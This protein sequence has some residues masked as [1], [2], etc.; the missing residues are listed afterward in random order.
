VVV[1]ER[2]APLDARAVVRRRARTFYLASLFLPP[3]SRQDVHDIY[4]Y[5]RHVDDLVD[6]PPVGWTHASVRRALDEL[7]I[8]LNGTGPTNRS[9]GAARRIAERYDIPIQYLGMVLE[10]ARI[11]L[12]LQVLETREDLRRYAVLMAGSVGIVMAHVLGARTA[13]ALAA[14]RSLG[15]AM[16]LTNILRDVGEDASRGRIYLPRT[17]LAAAGCSVDSIRA[18]V[19]TPAFRRVMRDISEEARSL[20][21]EGSAGIRY[22]DPSAQLAIALAATLYARILDKVERHDFDVFSRRAHVGALEK[23]LVV[24]PA[25]WRHALHLVEDGS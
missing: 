22:L 7:E 13:E 15:V 17:D 3:R 11:D 1:K 20:Y 6:E 23:W 2:P 24:I 18:G 16:Q 25:Y 9:V 4:A 5:Y 8:E 19:V 12:N 14:A 21:R 10:G